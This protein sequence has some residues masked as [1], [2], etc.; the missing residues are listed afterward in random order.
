MPNLTVN[1]WTTAC[2]A[3]GV[4]SLFDPYIATY[5]DFYAAS[6]SGG[7]GACRCAEGLVRGGLGTNAKAR[8]LRLH[9]AR[10][11]RSPRSIAPVVR[12]LCVDM[13]AKSSDVLSSWLTSDVWLFQSSPLNFNEPRALKPHRI[14]ILTNA[15]SLQELRNQRALPR[16]Q[17]LGCG[18]LHL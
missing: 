15:T 18:C 10:I 7:G 8:I 2:A 9:I 4:R 12:N 11:K 6:D 14:Q 17:A 16:A 5:V 1:S 3:F 13:S